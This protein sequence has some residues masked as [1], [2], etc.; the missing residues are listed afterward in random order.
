MTN[1]HSK[2]IYGRENKHI[3]PQ[4]ALLRK[5]KDRLLKEFLC[6]EKFNQRG[7]VKCKRIGGT[8]EWELV[9]RYC[10]IRDEW[11]LRKSKSVLPNDDTY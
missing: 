3:F 6:W 8:G 2:I 11:F 10:Y 5:E 9:V 1:A 4:P 7:W